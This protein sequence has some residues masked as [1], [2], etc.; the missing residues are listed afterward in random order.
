ME[1]NLELRAARAAVADAAEEL[2]WESELAKTRIS[3]A[4][5]QTHDPIAPLTLDPQVQ[6]SVTVPVVPQL[7]LGISAS[8]RGTVGASLSVSPFVASATRYREAEQY[9]RAVLEAEYR[10]ADVGYAVEAGAYGV[11]EAEAALSLAE[12]TRDYQ[13]D[14][15]AA[16][17]R[18][19][20]LG[21]LAYD[22]LEA[23]HSD[24]TDARQGVFDAQR[25]LLNAQV[26]L[27]RLLGPEAGPLRVETAA[28]EDMLRHID[29]RD[30]ELELFAEA[31]PRSLTLETMAVQVQR[32]EAELSATPAYRPDLRLTADVEYP[33]WVVGGSVTFS[34]SLTDLNTDARADLVESIEEQR[35]EMELESMALD[36]HVDI[37]RQSLEVSRTVLS[38]R[39]Q[40]LQ[41]AQ[42][43][44]AQADLHLV[45]GG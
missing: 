19:Y 17:E 14:R 22:A 23:V 18:A 7:S 45:Y 6:A 40:E 27:F 29:E 36:Y 20:E 9:R 3:A 41:E 8:G 26:T 13:E 35:M 44:L 43:I 37:L 42:T 16:S 1:G 34:F 31:E 2:P 30:A 33:D 24:L 4:A 12:A 38:S 10:A 11:M 21:E 28:V 5:N 15:L 39:Q 32:L 25:R